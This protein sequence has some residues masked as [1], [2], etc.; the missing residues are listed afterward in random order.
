MM[1]LAAAVVLVSG[2]AVGAATLTKD[3]KR[4]LSVTLRPDGFLNADMHHAFW[5]AMP[6]EIRKDPGKVRALIEAADLAYLHVM[7]LNRAE[8]ESIKASKAAGR[9]VETPDYVAE[10]QVMLD[11]AATDPQ[12]APVAD[13]VAADGAAR[14]QAAASGQPFKMGEE[15]EE[16]TPELIETNLSNTETASARLERLLNSI[17]SDKPRDY[18]YPEARLKIRWEG[19]FL[20]D[21]KTGPVFLTYRYSEQEMVQI[22]LLRLPNWRLDESSVGDAVKTMADQLG[23]EGGAPQ[24]RP[25]RGHATAVLSGSSPDGYVSLRAVA[26]PDLQAAYF[27]QATAADSAAADGLRAKLEEATTLE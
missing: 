10:K 21:T 2:T 20:K 4:I 23:V 26:L 25:W 6:A 7:R 27:L 19:P 24:V 14:L 5:A 12:L 17:W 15:E 18:D 1:L 3:Q 13:E 9:V 16:I 8:W 11:H 22:I